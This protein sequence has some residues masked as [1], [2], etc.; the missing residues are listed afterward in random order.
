M[1]IVAVCAGS[2]DEF[3]QAAKAKGMRGR[4]DGIADSDTEQ[5]RYARSATAVCGVHFT[6][7]EI[8]GSFWHRPDAKEIH[9]HVRARLA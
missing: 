5:W 1:K 9:D 7:I 8:I 6:H 3:L 4:M 2:L